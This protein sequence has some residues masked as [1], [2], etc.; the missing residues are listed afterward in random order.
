M[1]MMNLLF[2][3]LLVV[4]AISASTAA[5]DKDLIEPLPRGASLETS[6][7]WLTKAINKNAGY[8][9]VEDFVRIGDLKIDQCK[10]SYRIHQRYTDQKSALGDKPALG[11]TGATTA[12]DIVYDVYEDVS[13]SLK[14][15]NAAGVGLN[16]IPKPKSTQL[17]SL[18][19]TN[20][21]D[22]IKFDRKGSHVRFN[23][24]GMRSLT[25]IPVAAKAGEPIAKAFVY[26]IQL[27]QASK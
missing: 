23:T 17:I 19:T 25:A 12:N 7:A 3:S 26:V 5:Q 1:K 21:K 13:F 14:D 2:C 6:Q 9:L 11:V 10:V 22:A 27:C 15:L 20:K 18:E 4:G 24:Q 16:D 8:S